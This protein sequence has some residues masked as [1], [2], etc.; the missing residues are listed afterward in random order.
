MDFRD[1]E[2]NE[3]IFRCKVYDGKDA[4]GKRC[5]RDVGM[6]FFSRSRYRDKNGV[7]DGELWDLVTLDRND[8][9]VYLAERVLDADIPRIRW[10]QMISPAIVK[11]RKD[12][13]TDVV[14]NVRRNRR[15]EDYYNRVQVSL[16]TEEE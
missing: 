6:G 11:K 8:Q 3:L 2:P 16:V 1:K 12:G 4:R 14:M 7:W 5:L 9:R 15:M 13:T 10:N